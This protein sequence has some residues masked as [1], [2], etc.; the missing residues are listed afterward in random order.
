MTYKTFEEFENEEQQE[1]ILWHDRK[2]IF[3]LPITF[4]KYRVTAERLSQKKGLFNTEIDELLL[5]RVM[6]IEMKQNFG[7]KIFWVGTVVLHASDRSTPTFYL[8]NIRKPEFVKKYLSRLIETVRDEKQITGK[9]MFGAAAGYA[10]SFV[11][12]DGDGIPDHMQA[13][14]NQDGIADH[15]QNPIYR[16]GDQE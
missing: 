3:G 12:R 15:L 16:N 11:D 13:D 9:E 2:R 1:E 10:S 6:D 8:E 4:T 7:Q 5:Y 14:L